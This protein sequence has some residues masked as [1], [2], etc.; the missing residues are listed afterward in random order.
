MAAFF[1]IRKPA[2]LKLI[3]HTNER[4]ALTDGFTCSTLSRRFI[5]LVWL[6]CGIVCTTF[7]ALDR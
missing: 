5:V 2:N 6:G 3:N 1:Y 4:T 7:S